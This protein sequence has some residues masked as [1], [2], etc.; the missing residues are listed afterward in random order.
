LDKYSF[1]A[2]LR[3]TGALSSRAAGQRSFVVK[4][5]TF[6]A[7]DNNWLCPAVQKSPARVKAAVREAARFVLI[8]CAAKG[9][10]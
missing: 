1:F 4:G 2:A 5:F 6:L 10:R 8:F 9:M 3:M 7:Q